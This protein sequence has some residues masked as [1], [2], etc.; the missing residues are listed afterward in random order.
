VGE[1]VWVEGG[2]G[3]CFGCVCGVVVR[4]LWLQVIGGFVAADRGLRVTEGEPG[5]WTGGSTRHASA[6]RHQPHQA[7]TKYQPTQPNPTNPTHH[8]PT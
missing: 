6:S 3:G 5:T 1:C 4:G 7:T 8:N 2:K